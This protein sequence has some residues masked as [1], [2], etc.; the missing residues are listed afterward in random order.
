MTIAALSIPLPSDESLAQNCIVDEPFRDV[1]SSLP[2]NYALSLLPIIT[3]RL[4]CLKPNTSCCHSL[5]ETDLPAH[6]M[7]FLVSKDAFCEVR[8]IDFD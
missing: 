7:S 5:L 6:L 4:L 3:L 2:A 1:I 8:G